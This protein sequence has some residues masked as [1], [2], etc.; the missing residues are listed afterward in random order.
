MRKLT[1]CLLLFLAPALAKAADFNQMDVEENI[2][3]WAIHPESGKRY[4]SIK[5]RNLVVEYGADGVRGR[6]FSVGKQPGIMVVKGNVL[7]VACAAQ[8]CN[9]SLIDLGSGDVQNVEISG[10]GPHVL[11]ASAASNAYVYAITKGP[12]YGRDIL[13]VDVKTAK[14]K[15][16]KNTRIWNMRDIEDVVML[17]DG[18]RLLATERSTAALFSVEEDSLRFSRLD[19]VSGVGP[20]SADL[21]GNHY[22][23]DSTLLD[24][25]LKILRTFAGSPVVIHPYLDLVASIKEKT[26]Y[27]QTLS[28][29]KTLAIIPLPDSWTYGTRASRSQTP[30]RV[31]PLMAFTSEPQNGLFVGHRFNAG[32][33][34]IEDIAAKTG[35]LLSINVHPEIRA[36]VGKPVS[37]PL[38]VNPGYLDPKTSYSLIDAPSSLQLNGARLT[39]TPL[40]QEVGEKTAYIKAESG[41]LSSTRPLILS[42]RLPKVK[43][44]YFVNGMAINEEEK[45]LA[46]W[47]SGLA[48]IDPK[49]LAILS[50]IKTE[51]SVKQAIVSEKYVFTIPT[52]GNTLT[53]HELADLTDSER[54][55]LPGPAGV[56]YLLGEK[57]VV[58]LNDQPGK[59]VRLYYNMKTLALEQTYPL[60]PFMSTSGLAYGAMLGPKHRLFGNRVVDRDSGQYLFSIRHMEGIPPLNKS[61]RSTSTPG[62][63]APKRWGRVLINQILCNHRGHLAGKSDAR[64]AQI[65][66]AGPFAY[67]IEHDDRSRRIFIKFIELLEG[68]PLSSTVLGTT[69]GI[70]MKARSV[71]TK[72]H[73]IASYGQTI[74]SCPVPPDDSARAPLHLKLPDR[75]VFP[76]DK[77]VSLQFPSEGAVGGVNYR[78]LHSYN[79]IKIDSISG[80][81]TLDIPSIW[82]EKL[83]WIERGSPP[84]WESSRTYQVENLPE[85]YTSWTGEKLPKGRVPFSLPVHVRVRD[86]KGQEDG[87]LVQ[88]I[89][90]APAKSITEAQAVAE[91]RAAVTVEL[92]RKRREAAAAAAAA[93][94][95]NEVL[96]NRVKALEGRLLRMEATL[97]TILRKLETK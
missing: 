42:A 78:L 77:P 59:S 94:Q 39:W 87:Q 90:L 18:T 60:R 89:V 57:L 55:F 69:D 51:F 81:V 34:P 44:E 15:G 2:S 38:S 37:I 36:T 28:S 70:S 33:I 10:T 3:H 65:L 96:E 41:S 17:K 43:M 85:I 66:E 35:T 93:K 52:K 9:L 26:I 88:C 84:F 31:V 12:N 91:K 71:A 75:C 21:T 82:Q 45:H 76:V 11:F 49:T 80:E 5:E 54:I 68:Q 97:E 27:F 73:V 8:P 74:Y 72:D 56:I 47:G 86:D 40:L 79:G 32:F 6:N 19:S 25:K 24:A 1:L 58:E 64:Q 29:A 4:G 48:V 7:A 46:A 13:Q 30:A 22:T 20:K 63:L 16:Q 83:I 14:I 53:R 92:V 67:E 50:E 95:P 62:Q 23:M 61:T